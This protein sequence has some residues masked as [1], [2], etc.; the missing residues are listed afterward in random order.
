MF[1]ITGATGHLGHLVID[2]LLE[3]VA[4]DQIIAGARSPEKAA[5][6][7]AKGVAVRRF[8]YDD[9]TSLAPALDGV[10]HL[11][12]ISSSAGDRAAQH[13]RVI[14]AA[15]AAGVQ[16]IVYTSILNAP[17]SPIML[18]ADHQAT[19]AALAAAEVPYTLLRN[20]W[21]SE[22][23][24]GAL[25]GT[26]ERGVLIGA[27]GDG[28][29]NLASRADYAAAAVAA[30]LDDAHAGAVYELAGD[31]A[32]TYPEIAAV[33]AEVSG[34][35]V[36]YQD[37]DAAT[38]AGILE[39]VGVPAGFAA[40]LADSDAQGIAGGHLQSERSDL[41]RLIGRPTTPFAETIR[42]ALA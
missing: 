9:A 13:K 33:I 7:A 15:R 16:R 20:G 11:L 38:Y 36:A 26:I 1:F 24:T 41:R 6:L 2:Q 40:A 14:T 27:A 18:A 8:D 42:Q 35:P 29:V 30:L 37:L 25:A 19:E 17:S 34:K 32:L 28:R 5:D 3:Q 10:T 31:E 39:S 4:A 23:Y 21:Y 12:L 22:N